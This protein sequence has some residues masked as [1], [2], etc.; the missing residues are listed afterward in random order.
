MPKPR[1][2]IIWEWDGDVMRPLPRFA[3]ACDEQFV[4][5]ER[6][7]M[8]VVEDASAA[9]RGHYFASLNEAWRNLPESIAAE[10]P[11]PEALRKRALIQAGYYDEEIID[12]EN[13]EAALRVAAALRG[14]EEFAI[15]FVRGQFAIIRTAKSQSPRAMDKATFQASKQAVLEVVSSLIETTTKQLSDNAGRAA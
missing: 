12:C 11:S 2:L 10:Y 14:R 6:Y 9:T 7:K 5:H 15:T 13:N 4:V 8:E 1:R 3:K